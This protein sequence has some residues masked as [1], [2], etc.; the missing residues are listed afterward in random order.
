MSPTSPTQSP[1]GTNVVLRTRV[2]GAGLKLNAITFGGTG[3]Y[4]LYHAG[5]YRIDDVFF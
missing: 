3:A 1:L 2:P 5:F 4:Y